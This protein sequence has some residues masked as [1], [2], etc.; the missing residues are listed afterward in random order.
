MIDGVHNGVSH[1]L[2][3]LT[4]AEVLTDNTC[5]TTACLASR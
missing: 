4:I 2:D 3:Q 1:M 5:L